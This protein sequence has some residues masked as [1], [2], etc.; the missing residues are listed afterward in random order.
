MNDTVATFLVRFTTRVL[1]ITST[2]LGYFAVKDALVVEQSFVD[3]FVMAVIFRLSLMGFVERLGDTMWKMA[4]ALT[5][6]VKGLHRG[7]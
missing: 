4:K 5:G 7:Q 1:L 6:L 3:P 2:V